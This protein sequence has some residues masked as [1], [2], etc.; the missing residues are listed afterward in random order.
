M[1]GRFEHTGKVP[2]NLCVA[3][4]LLRPGQS[5]PDGVDIPA[6]QLQWVLDKVRKGALRFY[7][8]ASAIGKRE[9]GVK[10]APANPGTVPYLPPRL[11]TP[12][13]K[14]PPPKAEIPKPAA[15]V[16]APKPEPKKEEE[17]GYHVAY[18]PEVVKEE[19][20][21]EISIAR[22]KDSSEGMV[23]YGVPIAPKQ[24]EEPSEEESEA[25]VKEPSITREELMAMTKR[26]LVAMARD[27][28]I[29]LDV[30]MNKE[31]IIDRLLDE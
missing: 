16:V 6:G 8:A 30:K 11:G 13:V 25:E 14:T 18:V 4:H 28:G 20:V 17:L 24:E 26:Q 15:P 12:V 7:P 9:L 27:K 1:R 3:G 23:K 29:I 19:P 21:Q 10:P 22:I 31:S 2:R 5:T